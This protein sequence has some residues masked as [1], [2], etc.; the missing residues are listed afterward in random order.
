VAASVIVDVPAKQALLAEPD[1]ARR[2]TAERSLLARET[3]MLR[4][5][6]STPAPDL[7]YSPYSPN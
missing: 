3:T 1:A 5:V 6:P 7:R 4:A 2:L